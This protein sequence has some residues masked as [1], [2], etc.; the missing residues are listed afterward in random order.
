[1]DSWWGS[2][3]HIFTPAPK[4]PTE[5]PTRKF[6]TTSRT[7]AASA[8]SP[9]DFQRSMATSPAM[10]ASKSTAEQEQDELLAALSEH[11][12]DSLQ[13]SRAINSELRQQNRE[14]DELNDSADVATARMARVDRKTQRITKK[15]S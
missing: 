5:R 12:E 8:S 14:L 6:A 1:M 4:Q 10:D 7:E 11:L 9:D 3:V 15:Y 2:I 13:Q